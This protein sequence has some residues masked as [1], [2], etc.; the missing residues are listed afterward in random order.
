MQATGSF[1]LGGLV[2]TYGPEDH[3]GL[4]TIYL[5][6]IYPTIVKLDRDNDRNIPQ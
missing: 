3:Q 6:T 5:T 4:D 2:L 1:D